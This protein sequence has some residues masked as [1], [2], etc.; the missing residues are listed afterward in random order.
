MHVS[1]EVP[2][3]D[4]KI[5]VTG[6]N[7]LV[8]RALCNALS[9]QGYKV[10]AA[11]R[12]QNTALA[13]FERVIIGGIDSTTD[14]SGALLN[15]DAVIHLAARVHVM[16]DAVVDPLAEFRKV[17]VDGTLNLAMQA[18]K[19]G[20]R[21]FIFISSVKVNGEHTVNN[22]PFTEAD[23]ANPQDAY[24]LSKFEAEQGLLR[25]AQQTGME[26]VIIRPP[27]VYGAGVK[28]NFASMM[29]A[30]KRGMPLP[31]GA[32]HNQ[33]SFVYVDNLVSLIVHCIDAPAAA[34][35]V[36]LVSD[37]VGLSTSALMRA[38]AVALGVK[39]RLLPVP[40]KLIEVFATIL[41]KQDI[42]QRLCGN[43]QVDITKARTLL[44]WTPP[45]S[46]ADGL[47]ATAA[48]MVDAD[49]PT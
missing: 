28:A 47:K 13:G 19:A 20:V 36:F 29:R 49:V 46:V 33:R 10:T 6:A 18:A 27:L 44:G 41:G 42:A 8:G 1:T 5:L 45:V 22:K 38:C 15:V 31:L 14:W 9:Q 43:L 34:N 21:R 11:L 17:N 4:M 7:G 32:I 39:S 12:F 40:Q 48:G 37:G 16:H 23:I 2:R 3:V 24:G 26:V 35:Q 30:V 25:I